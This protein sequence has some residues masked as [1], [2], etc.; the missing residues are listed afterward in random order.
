MK[1]RMLIAF[2]L[3]AIMATS[4]FAADF[5]WG[6]NFTSVWAVDM[7]SD[8]AMAGLQFGSLSTNAKL[9]DNNTVTVVLEYADNGTIHTV[10]N[11]AFSTGEGNVQLETANLR[12]DI[13]GA[14]GLDLPVTLAMNNGYGRLNLHDRFN[15]EGMGWNFETFK[16]F[17]SLDGGWNRYI[18]TGFDMGIMD[19]VNVRMYT[20]PVTFNSKG[21]NFLIEAWAP[22]AIADIMTLDIGVFFINDAQVN[23]RI[24]IGAK[25]KGDMSFGIVGIG[26]WVGGTVENLAHMKAPADDDVADKARK[27]TTTITLTE[28]VTAKFAF[29]DAMGLKISVGSKQVLKSYIGDTKKAFDDADDKIKNADPAMQIAADMAFN[30]MALTI[31]GGIITSDLIVNADNDDQKLNGRWDFGV[32]YGFGAANIRMGV[33][34]PFVGKDIGTKVAGLP[35]G[36]GLAVCGPYATSGNDNILQANDD[37]ALVAALYFSAMVWF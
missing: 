28:A 15:G 2:A 14:L 18:Y 31:Y 11:N 8:N 24:L 22:I 13:F 6:G 35:G 36:D 1:K 37:G 7:G 3:I 23:E 32:G 9:D 10:A 34:G 26:F 30:Y 5:G 4:A 21:A 20:A 27:E 17:G 33:T 16:G 19:M 12:T 29:N 25:V